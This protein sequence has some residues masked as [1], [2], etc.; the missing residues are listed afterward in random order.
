MIDDARTCTLTT[1]QKKIEVTSTVKFNVGGKI[2]EISRSLLDYFPET[3]LYKAA[4]EIWIQEN[5]SDPIFI[6]RDCDRF[7]HVL[8]YMRDGY[9]NLPYHTTKDAV[10]N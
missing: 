6:E 4:S 10:L 7:H 3:M 8:D 9:I 1:T 2:F 5:N